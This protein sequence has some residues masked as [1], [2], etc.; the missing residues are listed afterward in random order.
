MLKAPDL[1]DEAETAPKE[2]A[3]GQPTMRRHSEEEKAA[4]ARAVRTLRVE[5]DRCYWF[6]WDVRVSS[7][8]HTVTAC[9]SGAT[10]QV[11][12]R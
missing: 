4:A 9:T 10:G 3:N 7:K 8:N 5:L 6:E 1:G 11:T 12:A 2:L